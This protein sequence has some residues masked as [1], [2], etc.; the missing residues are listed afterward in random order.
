[1]DGD[2]T[3]YVLDLAATLPVV[4]SDT[5]AVYLYGL[6]IIAQQQADRQYYFHDG[7][8][9]VR[10][11]LD[12]T[13]EVEANYAYDPF[14][15]PVVAG[16]TS[17]PHRFTGEAWDEEVE[18]LYLRARHYQP[19]TGRFITKDPWGGMGWVPGTL[20]RYVYTQNRPVHYTDPHGLQGEDEDEFNPGPYVPL[21]DR[22]LEPYRR[23]DR[24]GTLTYGGHYWLT[25]AVE[26]DPLVRKVF[27]TVIRRLE[28]QAKR[29]ERM[30]P[31]E[32][33]CVAV[34][35]A[36]QH[37]QSYSPSMC[38]SLHDVTCERLTLRIAMN[39]V[40]AVV[41][42]LHRLDEDRPDIPFEWAAERRPS[43]E[44][45]TYATP[46]IER[47]IFVQLRDTSRAYSRLSY[48]QEGATQ[49]KVY[50][51]F[52]HAFMAYEQR[53]AGRPSTMVDLYNDYVGRG[54]EFLSQVNYT[55][56]C[57]RR[58][59]CPDDVQTYSSDDVV[60][61]RWGTFFGLTAFDDPARIVRHC[62]RLDC[63]IG[64]GI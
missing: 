10:Q 19:E 53:W 29:Q 43:A 48:S 7:L 64:P 5:E 41:Q 33:F 34:T 12:T 40:A 3:Q 58:G 37:M 60:A 11:L 21:E 22:L 20:N 46:V 52:T 6:D 27:E 25:A 62:A 45:V 23:A 13:G 47:P 15:V 14:G 44:L 2:T 17:N 38:T 8:G 61:N 1:M 57:V 59:E 50:H 30:D 4:V 51:F 42:R 26:R 28:T 9:S 31:I 18:L 32:F 55:W 39:G 16:D 36:R 54:Y 35:A 49:D 24:W 63:R 56:Q